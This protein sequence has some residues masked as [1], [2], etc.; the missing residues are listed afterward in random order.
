LAGGNRNTRRKPAPVPL[1]STT[2]PTW[3]DLDSNRDR[4]GGKS[5]SNRL[6]YGTTICWSNLGSFPSQNI[7]TWSVKVSFSAVYDFDTRCKSQHY[8]LQLLTFW[9]LSNA[10]LLFKHTFRRLD[11]IS[12]FKWN[13][14]SWAQSIELV[15]TIRTWGLALSIG[16]NE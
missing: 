5:A 16:P 2:N 3:P 4:R 11:S 1:F 14:L 6:S 8:S 7:R 13:I 9:T 15:L 12:I 10:L